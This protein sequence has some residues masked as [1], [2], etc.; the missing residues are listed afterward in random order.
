MPPEKDKHTGIETLLNNLPGMVYRCIVEQDNYRYI[1]VSEGCLA[2]TG[3]TV[4][5]L[6]KGNEGSFHDTLHP[7]DAKWVNELIDET[8]PYGIPFEATYRIITKDGTLK[9]VWER[10]IVTEYNPDGSPHIIEGFDTDVTELWLLKRAEEQFERTNIMLDT[11]PLVCHLWS[12]DY[13][14][15]DMNKKTLEIF[16]M[17][18]DEYIIRFRELRPDTQPNGQKTEAFEQAMLEKAFK[19]G[20]CTYELWTKKTDGTVIPFEATLVRIEFDNDYVVVAYGRDLRDYKQMMNE[21][22][23]QT[24][25]LNEALS[26]AKSANAAKSDFLAKMS[27]EIRTPLNAIIGMTE[28]ALREEMSDVVRDYTVSAKQAGVNLLSI[29]NDILDLAKI[30][31]GKMQITPAVYSLASLINDAISIIKT[32]LVDSNLRF[33]AYVDSNLPD[34]LYGDE[35]RIRQILINTLEN[36]VK[37][38]DK[39]TI[40]LMIRGKKKDEDT[41]SLI[42]KVK[43]NGRG[44][45]KEDLA[46]LFDSYFQVDTKS[47]YGAKGVGLGLVISRDLANAM[48]GE[49]EVESEY[50]VGSTFTIT[51]PQQIENP[52]KIA[53]VKNSESITTILYEQNNETADSIIY[54]ITNLGANYEKASSVE[55]LC[56]KLSK[57]SYTYVFVPHVTFMQN[58]DKIQDLSK[59]SK[60]VLLTEFGESIPAY[61][62]SVISMPVNSMSV[63]SVFNGISDAF[64]YSASNDLSARFTAPDAKVLV[65]DDI[66]TNLKVVKGL[67]S[68]YLMEVDLCMSGMEAIEAVKEK[69]YDLIF[70]D[71]RMPDM[72]GVETTENI[73]ALGDKDSYFYNIPIIALTANAVAG[74]KEMFLNKGFAD[75]MSKPIDTVLLNTV[76][77]RW[78]PK[79]KQIKSFEQSSARKS[80]KKSDD[81]LEIEGL[82]VEKGIMLS[83]GQSGN[84]LE[85]LGVFYED[86]YNK[87]EDIKKHINTGD[88][89]MFTVGV[90]AIK[91]A[92]ANIGADEL[93]EMARA[94]EKA[95]QN[96]NLP[97][98]D[99]HAMPFLN[100][101]DKLLINVEKTVSS[102]KVKHTGTSMISEELKAELNSLMKGLEEMDA[103]VI[104]RSTDVMLTLGCTD[105]VKSVLRIISKHILMA[106]YDEATVMIETVLK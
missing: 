9:W 60:I 2:L 41:L 83:G 8:I 3:Y 93:S 10:S 47:D 92:L 12:S 84:F 23:N 46:R 57:N 102:K 16:E 79:E 97:Y 74:V 70:M 48:G 68:P 78:I 55:D 99:T 21:I 25:L 69:E 88:I 94:L 66:N 33:V 71:H 52:E 30:E 45:K 87:W 59:K 6:L 89:P 101:L 65:V 5:E 11:S 31:S 104:N 1:S 58:K 22:D 95:G 17:N 85:I 34:E 106:E 43:D 81:T 64:S 49:I 77:E 82:D 38:T 50:G 27:H 105:D 39:G 96:N 73:K 56:D 40:T 67:L 98:I 44:I 54:A 53:V 72:D 100:A 4:E 20:R 18:R 19:E 37:Y 13:Q 26:Q 35:T 14:L 61:N 29:V 103:Y 75:F 80:S 24:N 86:G 63:A 7:A 90:H 32:K 76:L 62:Y 42:L 91:G 28:L 51:L 36:A 15:L